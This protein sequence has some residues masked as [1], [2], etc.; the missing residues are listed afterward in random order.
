MGKV[1]GATCTVLALLQADPASACNLYQKAKGDST[2]PATPCAS[3][4][5]PYDAEVPYTVDAGGDP[6]SGA[7]YVRDV[8]KCET[9]LN[10]GCKEVIRCL[11]GT[12]PMVHIDPVANSTKWVF[13]V[14]G[15]GSCGEQNGND[16]ITDCMNIYSNLPKAEWTEMS[17][18]H[19][20]AGT[21]AIIPAGSHVPARKPGHG[22][23]RDTSNAFATYNRVAFNKCSYD[24]FMGNGSY[25]A[26]WQGDP[27]ILHFHG[28]RIIN[29][30]L[31]DLTR[32]RGTITIDNT[33]LTPLSA[34]T[35]IVFAGNS[36]GAGGLIMNMQYIKGLIAGIARTANVSFVLDARA[37]PGLEAEG[38]F[39]FAPS[40]LY[41]Q[42]D[43]GTSPIYPDNAP[44]GTTIDRSL[45][46]YSPGGEIRTLL[47]TWGNHAAKPYLDAGCLAFH[48]TDATKCFDEMHVA[49]HH[50]NENVFWHQTLQDSVHA[51]SFWFWVN[52]WVPGFVA[53]DGSGI[54]Y[55]DER[56]DRVVYQLDQIYQNR[57]L[58]PPLGAEVTP[59]N[60]MGVYAV[61][62]NKHNSLFTDDGFFEHVMKK[63]TSKKS[64]ERALSDF[65]AASGDT[66]AVEDTVAR[67]PFTNSA[68]RGWTS[69][70]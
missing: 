41:A 5:T 34:A 24:R 7:F 51:G 6:V 48:S 20:A 57:K 62:G 33:E 42:D 11:D 18:E 44:F 46:T 45:A 35:R 53:D 8:P 66:C 43:D 47:E 67:F 58:A 50:M 38:K 65:L 3:H 2:T 16:P 68:C 32:T 25:S 61:Y 15:G 22:I 12:R 21:S 10:S 60:R 19:A 29:A 26:T 59:T 27:V 13:T 37:L 36:G 14:Q 23:L 49:A 69:S 31:K 55:N 17:T 28:R 40:E 56:I 30:V 39:E 54:T 70:W 52:N 4:V 64:F 1:I 9:G 63:G